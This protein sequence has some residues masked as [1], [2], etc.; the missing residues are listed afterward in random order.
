MFSAPD[1]TS[2][3]SLT[4]RRLEPSAWA[5][6]RTGPWMAAL[7]VAAGVASPSSTREATSESRSS[8]VVAAT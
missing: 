2:A 3:S 7:R 6:V 5:A 4:W 8:R 1:C